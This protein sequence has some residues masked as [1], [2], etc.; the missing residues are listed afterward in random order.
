M[1]VFFNGGPTNRDFHHGGFCI[2]GFVS[3]VLYPRVKRFP[4][5]KDFLVDFTSCDESR[6]KVGLELPLGLFTADQ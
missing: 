1:A 6:R 5:E 3:L 2:V 4:G